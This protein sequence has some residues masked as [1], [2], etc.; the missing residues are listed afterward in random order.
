[1]MAFVNGRL[2]PEKQAV[3]PITD[4]GFLYGD[5]VYEAIRV[6]GGNPFLLQDHLRRLNGSMAGVKLAPPMSLIEIG[7]AVQ[8]VI[9]ANKM[10]EAVVRVTVTRGSG[11]RGFD[12]AGCGKPTLAI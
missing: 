4:R 7:R 10:S 9:A 11:P 12:T 8:K 5:G 1:M 6:Y 2:V 3:V